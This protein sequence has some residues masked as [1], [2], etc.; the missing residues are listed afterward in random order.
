MMH[1][2]VIAYDTFE[3]ATTENALS[4]L[5]QAMKNHGKPASIMTDHGSQFYADTV[6]AKQKGVSDFE[7]R[8]VKL[9]HQQILAGVRHPQ[10]NGKLERFHGE[11]QRRLLRF[12]STM[13]R[14][15]D[16]I[17]LFMKWYNME[18]PHM[19]LDWDNSETPVQAFARKMPKSG[20]RVI[21]EQTGEEYHVE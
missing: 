12:E 16:P 6:K 19:S 1:H 13:Q 9:G 17:D 10:T 7:K 21:D 18:G 3:H 11:I 2:V 8:L 5:K 4:V 14:V 20:T 15:S